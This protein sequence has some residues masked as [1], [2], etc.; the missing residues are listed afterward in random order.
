MLCFFFVLVR[1]VGGFD[2]NDDDDNTLYSITRS[3]GLFVIDNWLFLYMFIT[4][5][6]ATASRPI[7]CSKS[8]GKIRMQFQ[9]DTRF[10]FS[11]NILLVVAI[12][13]QNIFLLDKA[14]KWPRFKKQH[15]EMLRMFGI[16]QQKRQQHQH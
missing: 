2:T 15:S 10:L 11:N 14:E 3:D 13:D 16:Q 5:L 6:I 12:F 1:V 4:T 7:L 9:I 8:L